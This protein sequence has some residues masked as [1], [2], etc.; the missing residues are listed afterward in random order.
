[1][2]WVSLALI[3]PIISACSSGVYIP[4]E[5]SSEYEEGLSFCASMESV[6]LRRD[7]QFHFQ[8]AYGEKYSANWADFSY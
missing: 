3:L 6:E 7:C 1:M 8:F 2:R 5:P 4:E